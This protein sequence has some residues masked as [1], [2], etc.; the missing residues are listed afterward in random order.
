MMSERKYPCEFCDTERESVEKLVTLTM[1]RNGRW[2]IFENVPAKVCSNCG[3]RYYD[4]P[5]LLKLERMILEQADSLR[6]VEAFSFSLPIESA[7]EH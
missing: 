4:G 6:P 3:H 7:A 2:Y 5:T 1:K